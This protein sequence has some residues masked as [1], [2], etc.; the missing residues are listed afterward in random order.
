[1][2]FAIHFGAHC[3]DEDRLLKCLFKNRGAL[4]KRG[5]NVS[6]PGRY[7][8]QMRA[9]VKELRGAEAPVEKQDQLLDDIIIFENVDRVILS[10]SSFFG[11]AHLRAIASGP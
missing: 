2:K 8:P 6:G 7:R 3:T 4:G 10:H 9:A 1:M 11:S 5:I